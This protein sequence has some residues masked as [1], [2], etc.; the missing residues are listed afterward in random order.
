MTTPSSAAALLSMHPL[1]V[2]YKMKVTFILLFLV[3][4]KS[5]A[6][7]A[8]INREVTSLL[9]AQFA[10]ALVPAK[11]N[12][13]PSG[14][15]GSAG[16]FGVFY[17]PSE[18]FSLEVESLETGILSSEIEF[19]TLGASAPLTGIESS[20]VVLD[21]NGVPFL[22]ISFWKGQPNLVV[23]KQ[24]VENSK[25]IAT[26]WNDD[27]YL[28]RC[29]IFSESLARYLRRIIEERKEIEFSPDPNL[30]NRKVEIDPFAPPE[31]NRQN[32]S[33]EEQPIQPPRD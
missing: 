7:G 15:D 11:E 1:D 33:I 31:K 26:V 20:W 16:G 28:F 23:F 9:S 6:F 18:A 25:G 3:F 4:L 5:A 2:L 30:P 13:L 17:D 12:R 10:A 19:W 24:V 29:E 8:E 32:Q 27:I 14:Q 22:L 21:R